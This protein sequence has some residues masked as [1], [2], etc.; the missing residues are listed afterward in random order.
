[1]CLKYFLFLKKISLHF[2][3][4]PGA[5]DINPLQ[6]IIWSKKCLESTLVR[7]FHLVDKVLQDIPFGKKE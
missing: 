4:I 7:W 6:F 3:Y 1:M 5:N 2:F